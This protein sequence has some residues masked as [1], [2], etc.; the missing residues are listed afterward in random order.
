MKKYD[1][2]VPF[3][4][5]LPSG[6][7]ANMKIVRRASELG[8]SLH[9]PVFG[10]KIFPKLFSNLIELAPEETGYSSTLKLVKA[11]SAVAKKR[12]WKNVLV[13]ASH[14]SLRAVAKYLEKISDSDIINFE[15]PP[16]GII[17]YEMGPEL[18]IK[19]KRTLPDKRRL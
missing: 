11:L 18:S 19:N 16:A 4:F 10:E 13:V 7:E 1:V 8:R 9:L 3:A 17:E 6:L 15:I 14:N 2:V 5:G 12:G